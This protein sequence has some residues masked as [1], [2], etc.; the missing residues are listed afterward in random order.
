M[1]DAPGSVSELRQ[2]G[3]NRRSKFGV[4]IALVKGSKM[5]QA[6]KDRKRGMQPKNPIL[7]LSGIPFGFVGTDGVF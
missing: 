5:S 2:P 7:A 1:A 6:I 3:V 4:S